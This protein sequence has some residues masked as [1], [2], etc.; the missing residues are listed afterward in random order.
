MAIKY[1]LEI[2]EENPSILRQLEVPK[3]QFSIDYSSAF[4]YTMAKV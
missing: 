1:F 2:V 3:I 4:L